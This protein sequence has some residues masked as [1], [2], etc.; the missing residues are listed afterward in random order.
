[1]RTSGWRKHKIIGGVY[2]MATASCALAI[3]LFLAVAIQAGTVQDN[4]TPPWRIATIG[5]KAGSLNIAGDEFAF[6]L[7]VDG[8][9]VGSQRIIDDY[10]ANDGAT[11][12][13]FGYSAHGDAEA[14]AVQNNRA[15]VNAASVPVFLAPTILIGGDVTLSARVSA[16]LGGAA[17]GNSLALYLSD[18]NT[19]GYG[20]RYEGDGLTGAWQIV[21]YT[22]AQTTVLAQV[23]ASGDHP[24]TARQVSLIQA[25]D[26]LTVKVDDVDIGLSYT[27]AT[28]LPEFIRYGLRGDS[29][30][31]AAGVY[32]DDLTLDFVFSGACPELATSGDWDDRYPVHLAYQIIPDQGEIVTRLASQTNGASG[33]AGLVM[34]GGLQQKSKS[35]ALILNPD[36]DNLELFIRDTEGGANVK[37]TTGLDGTLPRWL[38]LVRNGGDVEAY[39]SEDGTNWTFVSSVTI[40]FGEPIQAGI[41]LAVRGTQQQVV[42]IDSAMV[43]SELSGTIS[44]DTTLYAGQ[45]YLVTGNLTVASGATLTIQEGVVLAIDPGFSIQIYGQ[46]QAQGAAQREVV[47]T[48]TQEQP[49]ESSWGYMEVK[50]GG[51]FTA[52]YTII[53]YASYG[54]LFN[55]GSFGSISN[56]KIRHTSTGIYIKGNASPTISDNTITDNGTAVRVKSVNGSDFS[57]ALITG[58]TIKDNAY[59]LYVNGAN[60]VSSDVRPVVTGNSIYSNTAYNYYTSGFASNTSVVLNATQNWWGT[61]DIATIEAGIYDRKDNS[62]NRPY[63][64]FGQF[65]GSDGGQPTVGALLLGDFAENTTLTTG[66]KYLITS[67]LTV[68]SGVTLTVEP[69]VELLFGGYYTFDVYGN[70][71]VS[72]TEENKVLFTSNQGSPAESD[73]SGIMVKSSGTLSLDHA[74]VE[75]ASYAVKFES[76]SG[77]SINNS[78]IHYSNSA[79]FVEGDASP[80]ISGNTLI[81]NSTAVSVQSLIGA[82]PSTALITGNTIKKNANGIYVVGANDASS[83]AQPVVVGNNIYD[84]TNYNYYTGNYV[85]DTLAVLDATQNWWGTTLPSDIASGIRDRNSTGL[86]WNRRPYVDYGQYLGEVDGLSIGEKLLLGNFTENTT[87]VSGE[88]YLVTNKLTVNSGVTLTIESGVELS[89]GGGSMIDVYGNLVV[90]GSEGNEVLFT[91]FQESPAESDWV[92]II[93]NSGGTLTLDY[94]I[95]EYASYGLKFK[96]GSF[97]SASNNLIRYTSTGIG[98]FENSSPLIENNTILLNGNGIVLS[99]TGVDSTNPDPQISGNDI[100]ENLNSGLYVYGYGGSSNIIV[101]ATDNWWGTPVPTIGADIQGG[102]SSLIDFSSASAGPN[103]SPAVLNSSLTNKYFSPG[104]IDASQD[105]YIYSVTL[106]ELSDW[107]LVVRDSAGTVIKTLSGTNTSTI[108]ATWDG[109]DEMNNA[110]G[111]DRYSVRVTT[112]AAGRT[113]VADAQKAIVDNTA[114]N[115]DI[116]DSQDNLLLRN[117]LQLSVLGT[118]QDLYLKHYDL[119]YGQGFNPTAYTPIASGVS[120]FKINKELALWLIGSQDD[121]VS[122]PN[123][124]YTVR[125]TAHDKAGNISTDSISVTIDNI[126]LTSISSNSSTLDLL[127]GDILFIDFSLNLPGDVSLLIYDETTGTTGE[128]IRTIDATYGSAGSYSLQWDGTDDNGVVVPIGAYIYVLQASDGTRLGIYDP[129]SITAVQPLGVTNTSSSFN[130]FKN[131]YWST[132]VTLAGPGRVRLGLILYDDGNR[133]IFPDGPGLAMLAETQTLYWDGRDPDTGIP[134]TGTFSMQVDYIAYSAN[135]VVVTGSN[136]ATQIT[137][138]GAHVQ[139]TAD[140]YLVYLSYGH[141]TKINY[142]LTTADN[143]AAQVVI[144]LLPPGVMDFDDPQA[145][146]IHNQQQMTGDHEVTWTGIDPND[147]HETT[148]TITTDGPFTFAIQ[149][150]VNG[151]STLYRGVINAYQ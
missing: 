64:D 14:I 66:E 74:I 103:R 145:I 83:D 105:T 3:P 51:T 41:A 37:Q 76:G 140:P 148:R 106:S 80:T 96:D 111:E 69:G 72:G 70:L 58:N 75:Y 43:V 121:S 8:T 110:V 20:V 40:D 57:T 17:A 93:V 54:V 16:D 102:N 5:P 42:A 7:S 101:D 4:I 22:N 142:H 60:N 23:A 71:V 6:S 100:F 114:P 90:S 32:I 9:C 113:G 128:P 65:L 88:K 82:N 147:T 144:K 33:I 125:L 94:S 24:S 47:F 119:E 89:F 127:L 149:A 116:N 2:R 68:D 92:G 146:E 12:P 134:Y 28:G 99:G 52:D 25:G 77:G 87:L 19:E 56:N 39:T 49:A 1:M 120:E 98:V 136:G 139:V 123:G 34:R 10:T 150:T 135:T 46:L 50:S 78:Q 79:I 48:S 112:T 137:G 21:R 132:D 118:A 141:Y 84:N 133:W 63:V 15:V 126:T 53:E 104:V 115:V 108:T 13:L 86:D 31:A 67:K 18:E 44:S 124:D 151:V 95:V 35:V 55:S 130:P 85:A 129:S 122:V 11:L 73:W 38:K 109:T 61:T 29:L 91:S 36:N 97:G 131:D 26:T 107:T 81:H 59:G 143:Q 30:T 117:V 45:N 27:E 138:S 62:S